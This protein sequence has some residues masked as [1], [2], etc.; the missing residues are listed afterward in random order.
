MREVETNEL[1]SFSSSQHPFVWVYVSASRSGRAA[2]KFIP[3]VGLIGANVHSEPAETVEDWEL[4]KFV[5]LCEKQKSSNLRCVSDAA[6]PKS[7]WLW[8]TRF[9]QSATEWSQVGSYMQSVCDNTQLTVINLQK[10]D[11]SS[12]QKQKFTLNSS[13]VTQLLQDGQL[14]TSCCKE[15]CSGAARLCRLQRV[16]DPSEFIHS[17]LHSKTFSANTDVIWIFLLLLSLLP[18]LISWLKCSW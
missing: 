6:P 4:L 10:L 16:G 5:C 7:L 9:S 3:E 17:T 8:A 15:H 18:S 11:F 13:T 2:G 12:Q 14:G 1:S